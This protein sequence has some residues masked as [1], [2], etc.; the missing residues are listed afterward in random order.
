MAEEK[1]LPQKFDGDLIKEFLG[2]QKQEIMVR[3]GELK[4]REKELDNNKDVSIASINAQKD[5][6]KDTRQH[7]IKTSII[8]KAFIGFG[9]LLIV[10]FIVYLLET[11]KDVLAVEFMKI[12]GTIIVSFGGGYF[13]GRARGSKKENPSLENEEG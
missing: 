1:N 10:G 3:Q 13:Y 8:D 12:A 2:I 11:G 9:F 4:V 5:D 7:K 6:L